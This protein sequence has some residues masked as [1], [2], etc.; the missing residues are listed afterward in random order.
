MV[1]YMPLCNREK[2]ETRDI[3]EYLHYLIFAVAHLQADAYV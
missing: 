1:N 2:G 3:L